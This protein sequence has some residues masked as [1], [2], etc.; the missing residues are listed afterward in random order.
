M[1][2]WTVVVLSDYGRDRLAY[3]G[4]DLLFDP[5]LE[6]S[7]LPIQNTY[8]LRIQAAFAM[9]DWLA[10]KMPQHLRGSVWLDLAG[11]PQ[12]NQPHNENA[13]ERQRRELDLIERALTEE[14]VRADLLGFVR[15]ALQLTRE[16][17][18]AVAWEAPRSLMLEVLP[19]MRR[20]LASGWA[21]DG[22]A[23]RGLPDPL[24][25]TAGLRPSE[26]VQRPEP[27]RDPDPTPA[28][29]A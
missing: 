13:P 29:A 24:A 15:N 12:R 2:P 21:S 16:Q 8:V 4:Y 25:A 14:L 10:S 5:S 20:R 11:P 7:T 28:R 1:R 3:Q 19:T 6:A 27:P 23:R 26:P 9:M 18:Q 22:H 17:A